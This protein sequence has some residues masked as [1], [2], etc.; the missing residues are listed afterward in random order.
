MILFLNGAFGIGKSTVSR[1]LVERLP[2]AVLFDPEPLGIALQRLRRVDDFQDLALWR[3]LTLLGLR[4]TRLLR[5]NVIVPLAISN[6]AYLAELRDGA[7]RFD[8]R[9]LHVCLVA[10]FDVVRERLR[11]RGRDA[12]EWELRRARECCDAHGDPRFATQVSAER[13][14]SAIVEELLARL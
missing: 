4:C 13:E 10:P 14:P 11:R 2:R 3:R 1:A 6:A 5:P 9:V 8:A 7:S 12:G